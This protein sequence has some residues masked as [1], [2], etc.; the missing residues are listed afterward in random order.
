MMS[1]AS[2]VRRFLPPNSTR[3]RPQSGS[4]AGGNITMCSSSPAAGPGKLIQV[5]DKIY[6]KAFRGNL[7]NKLISF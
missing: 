3:H 5:E 2:G 1:R 4:K 7:E 6:A